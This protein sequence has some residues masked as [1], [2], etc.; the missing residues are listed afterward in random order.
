[1]LEREVEQ[2]R[3]AQA[4]QV[5]PRH[6]PAVVV[7]A[8]LQPLVAVVAV[9]DELERLGVGHG[10]GPLDLVAL[11]QEGLD[12]L[13]GVVVE[14]VGQEV[15]DLEAREAP[16]LHQPAEVGRR[17]RLLRVKRAAVERPLGLPPQPGVQLLAPESGELGRLAPGVLGH[18]VGVGGVALHAEAEGPA[19]RRAGRL[20]APQQGDEAVDGAVEDRRQQPA[21]GP[22]RLPPGRPVVAG[23]GRDQLLDVAARPAPA[24]RNLDGRAV[25]EVARGRH[26]VGDGEPA[27]GHGGE[28]PGVAPPELVQPEGLGVPAK[29]LAGVGAGAA[30]QVPPVV[31]AV[32]VVVVVVQLGRSTRP[33]GEGE[34]EVGLLPAVSAKH[35]LPGPRVDS[36]E[37]PGGGPL[38][39]GASGE[40]LVA[41]G[42]EVLDDVALLALGEVEAAVLPD[43]PGGLFG[44]RD[45]E[46][47]RSHGQVREF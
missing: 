13:P 9:G 1:M 37:D 15:G 7:L 21:L 8:G 31:P 41:A 12:K 4:T 32:A 14:A 16:R 29:G 40:A 22:R 46:G 30:G 27:G 35:E 33:G 42:A 23:L 19:R 3:P 20:L 2:G 44:A 28:G 38:R 34:A 25:G 17:Q 45:V 24:S 10:A 39:G 6:Q 26:R 36:R 47:A 43:E 11:A 18:L 5:G